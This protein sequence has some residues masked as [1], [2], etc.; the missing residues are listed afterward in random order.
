VRRSLPEIEIEAG[1][2]R[3]ARLALEPLAGGWGADGVQPVRLTFDA[4]GIGNIDVPGRLAVAACPLVTRSP[5]IDGRLDDWPLAT[6]NQAGDFQ[7][8]LRPAD[9]AGSTPPSPTHATR[10]FFVRDADHLYVAVRCALDAGAPP[11][12]Q[13]DNRIPIDG[14][15]PW[16]QDVVEILLDP[17][18]MTDGTP[19][20]IFCLQVKPTGLL[21]AMRGCRMDPPMGAVVPWDS[22][23]QVAVQVERDVWVV[24]LALPLAALGSAAQDA[25]VW[26]CNVTRLDARLGEYSSWSGARGHCYLPDRLGSLLLPRP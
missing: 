26:G 14:A 23:A 15:V 19:A 18:P 21:V 16:G 1:G 20:D 22:G 4:A 5:R 24:E 2:R 8:V 3:T 11:V 10:A 25:I 6:N 9:A 13:A 12:W 17:R 7:L